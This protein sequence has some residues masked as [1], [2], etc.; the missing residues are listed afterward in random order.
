MQIAQKVAITLELSEFGVGQ[1]YV[2][3]D[4]DQQASAGY[5]VL[6]EV[7]P[8]LRELDAACKRA[9]EKAESAK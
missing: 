3:A 2:L 1:V 8:Q 5:R 6:A 9:A 4:D 7:T